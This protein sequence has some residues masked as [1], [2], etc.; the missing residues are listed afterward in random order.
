[1]MLGLSVLHACSSITPE[2]DLRFKKYD[3]A[4]SD[5]ATVSPEKM[6]PLRSVPP[7]EEVRVSA[8]VTSSKIPCRTGPGCRFSVGSTPMWVTLSGEVRNKCRT[9]KLGGDDL[10]ERLERLLGL[11]PD[12]PVE[13]Q[14][15][16]FVEMIVPRESL[17]RP[18]LGVDSSVP[19]RTTCTL[20][21][22]NSQKTETVKLVAQQMAD[23]YVLNDSRSPGYPFTRLGYT[24]D[25]SEGVKVG[26]HYGASEFIVSPG[27]SVVVT[28][29]TDTDQYCGL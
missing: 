2:A 15:T 25:W 10:R 11:P 5:A 26:D 28:S 12:S 27:T 3:A 23:S 9:W 7:G 8:W 13:Y 14:K 19:N 1:M 20:R 22:N 29:A 24:Y 17:S 4:V 18:C 21:D 16:V 6:L